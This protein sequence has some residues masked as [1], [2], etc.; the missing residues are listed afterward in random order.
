MNIQITN[1]N[2]TFCVLTLPKKPKTSVQWKGIGVQ[3][4]EARLNGI[5]LEKF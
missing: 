1:S 3:E 2:P 5:V 4:K